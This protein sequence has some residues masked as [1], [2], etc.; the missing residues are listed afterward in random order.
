MIWLLPWQLWAGKKT[1]ATRPSVPSFSPSLWTFSL[2][3][4]SLSLICCHVAYQ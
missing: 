1:V 3:L 2:A 4:L